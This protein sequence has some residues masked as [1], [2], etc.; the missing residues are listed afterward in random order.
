[1]DKQSTEIALIAPTIELEK[2][3]KSIIKERNDDIEVYLSNPKVDAIDDALRIAKK[4]AKCGTRIIISRKGTAVAIRN[5]NI[6]VEVVAINTVLSDYIKAIEIAQQY[7]G[8]IAFFSYDEMTEEVKTVCKMLGINAKYYTF[9]TD[10]DSEEITKQAIRDGAVLGIGGSM[11]QK[12]A[13]IYNLE[14]ITI[15]NTE[16]SIVTAIE[17]AEQILLVQKEELKKQEELQIQLERY[18]AVLNFT[19]DAIIAIDEKG[20]IDVINPIAE[21]IVKVAPG[22]AIG[23]HI[24]DVIKNTKM[25]PIEEAELNQL[26]DI[27]GTLVSTNRVP[28][29]VENEVK[30]VVA[31]F[32]DI[33]IIQENENKI[34]RR[35]ADKGLV[36]KYNFR[37]IKGNSNS[38]KNTIEIAKSYAKSDSTILIQGETGTGKELFAQ[39]IHN[40]SNRKDGPFVAIN[41][42]A[43]TKSLLESELFG[44]EEGAFTGASK[45]GKIGLF[46][47]AHKGTI[48]LDEIGEIPVEIQ[49]QLL[50]VLQEKQIRRIGS[51]VTIPIDVR[52]ITATNR[53]L[54]QEVKMNRF[55]EDLFYRIC[56]L[57]LHVPPLRHRK[58]DIEILSKYFF[59]RFLGEKSR[60]YK[61]GFNEIMKKV[62]NHNWYGNVRELEN[63]IERMSVLL[64]YHENPNEI[65]HL[66][67]NLANENG[68]NNLY[69]KQSNPIE[70]NEDNDEVDIEQWEINNILNALKENKLSIQNTADS[71]GISRTTLWRKMKKYDIKV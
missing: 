11:N 23:K 21:K 71:L 63:F 5:A 65:E 27:N 56:V 24:N 48:F 30:G 4:L 12:Y 13:D 50:R 36:A 70:D 7:D 19:H 54:R 39:S 60:R 33:K 59:E 2:K 14:H 61:S 37:D 58:G 52:V 26:I 17:T 32:Q 22:Y 20:I 51:N 42:A 66:I 49:A 55:R 6:G 64:K 47:L 68:V 62:E 43:L 57:N 16:T 25:F 15:E 9:K 67:G 8:L 46:E 34:R 10:K 45:G 1:M 44:Y 41:C 69:Y 28:I 3:T 31:T 40:S 29:I 35:L 53:D 18:K 38:L